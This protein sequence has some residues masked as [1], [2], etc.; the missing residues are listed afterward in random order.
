MTS[1]KCAFTVFDGLLPEPHNR[2]VTELLFTLAHWHALAKLRMH[3][4]LT[5]NIMDATTVSLGEKLRKFSQK[6]CPAFGTKELSQEYNAR[7]RKDAKVAC[8]T[9]TRKQADTSSNNDQVIPDSET[10]ARQSNPIVMND[11]NS[12]GVINP[13]SVQVGGRLG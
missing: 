8:K 4:D 1:V 13:S 3:N 2:I 9:R 12:Q 10:T 5:L 6:T 7:M 11:T